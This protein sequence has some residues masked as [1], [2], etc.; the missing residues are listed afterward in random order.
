MFFVKI[1]M[2]LSRRGVCLGGL[3]EEEEDGDGVRIVESFWWIWGSLEVM[4]FWIY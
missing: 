1:W 3:D 4:Y 2:H